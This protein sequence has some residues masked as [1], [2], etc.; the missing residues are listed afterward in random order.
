M[1]P[2]LTFAHKFSETKFVTDTHKKVEEF[3]KRD[4]ISYEA[5]GKRDYISIKC[6]NGG[7]IQMQK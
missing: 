7:R 5:P 3:Y 2:D 4:D 1:K 6:E